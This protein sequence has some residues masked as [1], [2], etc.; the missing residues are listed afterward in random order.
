MIGLT[1]VWLAKS[2]CRPRD[3][4]DPRFGLLNKITIPVIGVI[5]VWF[6]KPNCGLRD[7][8]NLGEPNYNDESNWT[9]G[10][11]SL[12]KGS[13]LYELLTGRLKLNH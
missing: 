12:I 2:G 1:W 6:V 5:P 10:L 13:N 9:I 4:L 7:R 11:F 8:L 3:R